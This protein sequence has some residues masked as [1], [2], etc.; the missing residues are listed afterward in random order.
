MTRG[1]VM[2]TGGAGY[3]GSHACKALAQAGYQPVVYDSLCRGHA[4][5]VKWGP[6]EQG[7]ILNT[8]RLRQVFRKH[9]PFAVLHFAALAYVG[10]SM[11]RPL[12][13]HRVNVAGSLS[14]L[15]AMLEEGVSRLVFSSSCATYGVPDVIPIVEDTLQIPINTYGRSKLLVEQIIRDI[16]VDNKLSAIALRYFNAAGAD[17]DGDT[18]E[19]HNP[20][21]HIIPLMLASARKQ[22]EPLI[23]FG[24]DYPTA[25]GTCI[26][27]YIHVS[28][29]AEAHVQALT[30]LD[31]QTG[32]RAFNLG[33]GTGFSIRQLITAA[34]G[35]TGCSVP[36]QYGPRRV[37][38]P[39]VL[40]ADPSLAKQV[41]G[42]SP[43]Y[44]ELGIILQ[45]AW[46]WME[47]E[48]QSMRYKV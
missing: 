45:T 40:V 22:G 8:E 44:S 37:G 10:E 13:Y 48:R 7:D 34:E 11:E 4:Q 29:L 38:D 36:V 28:D 46:N 35:I 25:D 23:V 27:D 9:K 12:L 32:F 33:T 43:K 42:W 18:G 20:E 14:L 19:S 1:V 21:T 24:A 2:V 47:R 26:R 17:P 16:A 5:A 31:L 15:S 41:L 3:I 39:P 6:L 30:S